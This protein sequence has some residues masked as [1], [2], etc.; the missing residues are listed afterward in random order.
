MGRGP[1]YQ[2]PFITHINKYI[3]AWG[4]S[5]D[6]K[7]Q[8]NLWEALNTLELLPKLNSNCGEVNNISITNDTCNCHTYSGFQK[9]VDE[10]SK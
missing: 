6:D 8:W 2:Q 4:L 1:F 5:S 10:T 9:R 3:Y 7:I